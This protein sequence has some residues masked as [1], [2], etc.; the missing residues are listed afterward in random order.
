MLRRCGGKCDEPDVDCGKA[1]S[2]SLRI[3][4]PRM[5]HWLPVGRLS[6]QIAM[7]H[8]LGSRPSC[9]SRRLAH[10]DVYAMQ[11]SHCSNNLNV[12]PMHS[13]RF[14]IQKSDCGSPLVNCVHVSFNRNISF[15]GL[16]IV[17]RFAARL[18]CTMSISSTLCSWP[19]SPLLTTSFSS[20]KRLY[21]DSSTLALR[22]FS[23]LGTNL[24]VA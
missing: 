20:C 2:R 23:S 11:A 9:L 1:R 18:H 15:H 17:S 6:N 24:P 13:A 14:V 16:A 7:A 4:V 22:S 21:L 10:L 8:Q 19:I 3:I 12:L 5:H